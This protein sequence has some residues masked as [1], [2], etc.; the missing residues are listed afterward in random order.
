[1]EEG[2]AHFIV[3]FITGAVGFI[4]GYIGAQLIW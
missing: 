4:G 1:M 2:D 3:G